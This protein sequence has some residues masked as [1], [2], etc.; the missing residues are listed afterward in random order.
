MAEYVITVDD[1]EAAA[2]VAIA[3]KNGVSP[4]VYVESILK[5]WI[6]GQVRGYYQNVFNQSTIQELVDIFG[7]PT[8]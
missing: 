6:A 3:N 7:E 8:F 5:N 2:I 1:R 4:R